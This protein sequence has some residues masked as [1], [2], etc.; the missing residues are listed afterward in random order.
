M[1]GQTAVIALA[2]VGPPMRLPWCAAFALCAMSCSGTVAQPTPPFDAPTYLNAMVDLMQA[3]SYYRQVIDWTAFRSAVLQRGSGAT[4]ALG[5]YP[6]ISTAL[7][8]LGQAGDVHSTYRA[9]HGT[10]VTN[11]L[12]PTDCTAPA[13]TPPAVPNSVGYVHVPTFASTTNSAMQAFVG[14]LQSAIKAA[15]QPGLNGWIVDLRGNEGGNM[16]PMLGGV[17]PILGDGAYGAFIRPTVSFAITC[18]TAGG[19]GDCFEAGLADGVDFAHPYQLSQASPRVAVL[20]DSIT[21]SAGELVLVCFL[22]RP[23]TRVFGTHTCG[24]PTGIVSYTLSD[25][26]TLDL[27]D[28]ISADRTGQR[29]SSAIN[30][31]QIISDPTAVV[32]AAVAWLTGPSGVASARHPKRSDEPSVHRDMGRRQPQDRHEGTGRQRDP[33]LVA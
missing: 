14:S 11:P 8:L 22:N 19:A 30:P 33:D 15:D 5:A 23:N 24:V 7:Q 9:A 18:S 32:E 3:N 1:T 12:F 10:I 6:A 2:G 20:T 28:S 29:Y 25:Q 31:D 16:W 21:A 4:T 26:A 13:Y 27:E 17:E